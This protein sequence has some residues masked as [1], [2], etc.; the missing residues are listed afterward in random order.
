M[1]FFVNASQKE[2]FRLVMDYLT[3]R[4]MTISTSSPPSYIEAEF[5]SLVSLS[6]DNAKGKVKLNVAKSNG[7]AYANLNLDFSLEYLAA[8]AVTIIGVLITYT[9]YGMLEIPFSFTLL[10]ML[11]IVILVW[12]LIGYSVSLTRRKF[13]EEFN[14]FIQSLASKKD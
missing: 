1:S 9:Y 4:R 6:L 3:G 11:S 10:I 7:G 8:L 5:G 14:M 12:G 13:I 2:A